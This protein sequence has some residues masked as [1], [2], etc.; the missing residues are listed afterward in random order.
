MVV[1][2]APGTPVVTGPPG[3]A[4]VGATLIADG[5]TVAVV[6]VLDATRALVSAPVDWRHL[7]DVSVYPAGGT[8][9][10]DDSPVSEVTGSAPVRLGT[11]LFAHD[12]ALRRHPAVR[13]GPLEV[14]PSGVSVPPLLRGGVELPDQVS[15]GAVSL[16][17]GRNLLLRA[18][19]DAALP[20]PAVLGVGA[21]GPLSGTRHLTLEVP[22]ASAT[23]VATPNVVADRVGGLNLRAMAPPVLRTPV[24]V[25]PGRVRDASWDDDGITL[26]SV[27]TASALLVGALRSGGMLQ[28]VPVPSLGG[29]TIRT[30]RL[31]GHGWES[32]LTLLGPTNS[33]EFKISR[34]TADVRAD[35]GLATGSVTTPALAT[36]ADSLRLLPGFEARL[37]GTTLARPLRA[38]DLSTRRLHMDRALLGPDPVLRGTELGVEVGSLRVPAAPAV[39]HPRPDR[40]LGLEPEVEVGSL[41]AF[42]SPDGTA[43]LTR[44]ETTRSEGELVTAD[45]DAPPPD[46]ETVPGAPIQY[47]YSTRQDGTDLNVTGKIHVPDED[48]LPKQRTPLRRPLVEITH[49]PVSMPGLD[50]PPVGSDGYVQIFTNSLSDLGLTESVTFDTCTPAPFAGLFWRLIATTTETDAQ[51]VYVQVRNLT[52]RKGQ[53]LTMPLVAHDE[54]P[55]PIK[56][57]QTTQP[58]VTFARGDRISVGWAATEDIEGLIVSWTLIEV[59]TN[60]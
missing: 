18:Y 42:F 40:F 8:V 32:P 6:A 4:S 11:S 54:F 5:V 44:V 35:Q 45:M 27:S 48:S 13:L 46:L 23:S 14:S 29:D 12:G 30:P 19:G 58:M 47:R 1:L 39:A 33:A 9:V 22:A 20:T 59:P 36:R 16:D 34:N 17:L 43:H 60:G 31:W 24:L 56:V 51:E 7:P 52:T 41:V 28:D 53:K 49:A 2:S 3:W 38:T 50:A 21:L 37:D 26:P 25:A 15:V 10:L 55:R 57:A